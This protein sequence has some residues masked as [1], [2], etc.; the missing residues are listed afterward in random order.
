MTSPWRKTIR[1]FQQE[2]TRTVLVIAAISIGMVGFTAV[3]STYAVL[4][5]EINKGYLA[6]NPASAT[7]Q[8][9]AIDDALVSAVLSDHRVSDAEPRR[10]VYG[11]IKTGPVQWRDLILFVIKDYGNIRISKLAPDQGAWPPKAGE[12]LIERDA[13]HVA[14]LQIG[15]TATIR[16]GQGREQ[17]LRVSG[18][19]HDV[20]PAQARMENAVYGY[21]TLDTLPQLGE[22]PYLD[23]L[24]ILVAENRFDE[25]HVRDVTA[26][27]KKVIEDRGHPVR[28]VDVPRPGRHPH[29]DL[30]DGFLLA[31][32]SFGLFVLAMSG[33]LVVNLLMAIM[34]AQ[35][36]QIGVMKA[37]GGTRGQVARIYFAQ[38][39][40]LGIAATILALPLG[41]LAS[42]ALCWPF[43]AF[44][45]FDITSFAV[46]FWVYAL[47][48]A[49]GVVT[50]L[51][52][53][54]WPIWKGSAISV[55]EALA[56]WGVSQSTFG[57]STFDRA[58]ATIGGNL[59]P[60]L[61]S[62]RNSFRRRT[63]LVLTIL[64]LAVSGL[65]F[66]S[67]LNI[68]SSM[69]NTLDRSFALRKYD[70]HIFLGDMYPSEK[71]E[72]AIRKTPGVIRAESWFT[73]GA[74]IPGKDA[75]VGGGDSLDTLSFPI[76]ALPESSEAIDLEI[77]EGRN[78][79]PG[80]VDALV[81][82]T[83][84]AEES[85][86]RTGNT[87]NL[88]FTG[89]L[90][91]WHVVGIAREPFL[92]PTAYIPQ[93]FIDQ[94]YP[95]M[96]TTICLS[97]KR[98]DAASMHAVKSALESNLEQKGIRAAGSRSKADFR[99]G[100][101]QH[102]LL[103]Y[104]F[105]VVISGIIATVGGLGLATTMSLN[106]MERRREMGV[107]R[108][109]G[110]SPSVVMGIIVAEGVVIGVMSWFLA[111][112]AAWPLSRV[113][114]NFLTFL[115]FKSRL[116]SVFQLQGLWIWLV[117]SALSA[118]VASL[119]PARSAAKLTVREALAYE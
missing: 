100:R 111:A 118:G 91:V 45:N 74:S 48:F 16:I 58:M 114:G 79:L 88:R 24:K 113:A 8:T 94:R 98:T 32:A 38:A 82:N 23:E 50:P 85:Q 19:V 109:I 96:R 60:L 36:R 68:R 76:I 83:T 87:I 115:I 18:R 93:A 14:G 81:I 55:R 35:V 117:F 25:K 2:S 9:D 27:V 69:S 72:R 89:G 119:L 28:G 5:R 42:R 37:I 6:S 44:L 52:A 12:M 112:L 65:F 57:T 66:M 59:R 17:N 54:A 99:Y 116:D 22:Q 20:G 63:R 75:S 46:P 101:D 62:I 104:V 13:F 21:I 31:M 51:L 92:P 41:M 30:M 105:L 90:T 103:I 97:L 53:A 78:L 4:T 107:L 108:A 40:L 67:A 102:L 29:A 70:L 34:A 3:L 64:T 26:Y 15:D 73:S 86:I 49:V 71:I 110:A 1:D 39:A 7:L 43:A 61:L 56:A 47:A 10:A 33:V 95:A 106:V 11:S 84:L 77:V 80:D